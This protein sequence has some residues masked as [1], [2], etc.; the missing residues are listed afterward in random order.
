MFKKSLLALGV[1]T[2]FSTFSMANSQGPTNYSSKVTVSQLSELPDDKRVILEGRITSYLGDE[3]YEF[4]DHSGVIKVE[5]KQED[6][7]YDFKT[8]KMI[9]FS[10]NDTVLLRGEVDHEDNRTIVEVKDI[11]II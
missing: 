5:I 4:K 1:T 2:T 11:K 3:C 7:P 8:N 6:L 9:P 10:D